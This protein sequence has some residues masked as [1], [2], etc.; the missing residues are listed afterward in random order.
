MSQSRC[1]THQ[2]GVR[3]RNLPGRCQFPDDADDQQGAKREAKH[4]VR[5]PDPHANRSTR[6]EIDELTDQP[7]ADHE[8]RSQPVNRDRQSIVAVLRRAI[9]HDA[10][11]ELGGS[12]ELLHCSMHRSHKR[13]Q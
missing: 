11:L 6:N 13:T 12:G 5:R 9:S 4:D 2:T 1:V 8:S 7:K 3:W 10:C